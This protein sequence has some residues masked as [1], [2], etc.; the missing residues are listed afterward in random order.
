MECT[1]EFGSLQGPYTLP[2]I[3]IITP[4]TSNS[5]IYD[6]TMSSADDYDGKIQ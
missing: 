4:C 2:P 3:L 1:I 6:I 5:L